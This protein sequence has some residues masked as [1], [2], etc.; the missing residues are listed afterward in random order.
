[1]LSLFPYPRYLQLIDGSFKLRTIKVQ[2]PTPDVLFEATHLQTCLVNNGVE[3]QIVLMGSETDNNIISFVES[4][5]VKPQ[6]YRLAITEQNVEII[7]SDQAGLFYGVVTL[8]QIIDQSAPNLPCLQIED[9]PDFP[10]RGFML[11]ISRDRVPTMDTLYQ[12]IDDLAH[13]K[14]NHLQLYIEHTFAYPNHEQ[15]WELASP[16]TSEELLQLDRYCRER[17]I[18]LV[19]NQNSLGHMERWLKH[20]DYKQLAEMPDGFEIFGEWRSPSTLNPLDP[21]SIELISELYK[22]LLPHFSSSLFNVGCDEPWELG[23]GKSKEAVAERGGNVYLDW[24][25]KLHALVASHERKM[26]VWGDIIIKYP[27]LIS[28]LPEDIIVMEWGYEATHPFDAN[29][30]KY[31]DAN[32]PFYDCP[33]TSSWNALT[34]R[35]DNTIEN[36]KSA[37]KYGL[38]HGAIGYL[39]T[40][41]GDKG[42]WQPLVASYIGIAYGAG[43]SWCYQT[44]HDVDLATALN[45]HLYHDTSETMG[46]LTM[47]LAN[48]YKQIKPEHINGQVLAYALQWKQAELQQRLAQV[49]EWDGTDK[50]DISPDNLRDTITQLHTLRQKLSHARIHRSDS[51]LIILEWQQATDLLI[52]GAEWLLMLQGVDE[53]TPIIQK[54]KLQQLMMTQRD[55]WLKR[56]RRGGLEDSMQRFETLL[57]QYDQITSTN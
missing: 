53:I 29:C 51:D 15:V 48:I 54:R 47:Q 44:N 45:H 30:K 39:I 14:I 9:A 52:H 40:D 13:L 2:I 38:Q 23:Q 17:H 57:D 41:W 27:D 28:E 33:G 25:L 3:T 49:E 43:V 46:D 4:S 24:L 34:G 55:L 37:A 31:A 32:I 6:G 35:A 21:Q 11:D 16:I 1:M 26:M 19:P 20:P 22:Y 56:S 10:Q 5:D 50:A 8:C 7:Y 18:H 36:L 42:H 12:L